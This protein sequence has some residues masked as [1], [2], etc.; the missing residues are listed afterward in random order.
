[1]AP[2]SAARRALGRG[3]E[4]GSRGELQG[5]EERGWGRVRR[6]A[7]GVPLHPPKPP[8][9]TAS[10]SFPQPRATP[11]QPGAGCRRADPTA[12]LPRHPCD[13]GSV[14][15]GCRSGVCATHPPAVGRGKPGRGPGGGS[16]GG[17]EAEGGS[18]A[19]KR[20]GGS[21]HTTYTPLVPSPGASEAAG[22]GEETRGE[23]GVHC[24][25]ETPLPG[26]SGA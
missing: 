4:G 21:A 11:A 25:A 10:M 18:A 2:A 14:P 20:A 19:Q 17:A 5:R 9:T 1:M 13:G 24:C 26:Q 15:G 3:R 6:G 7:V 22:R 16:G 23:E 8:C 12:E